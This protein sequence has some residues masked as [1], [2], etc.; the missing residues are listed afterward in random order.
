MQELPLVV[1]ALHER[2]H[3]RY[4]GPQ[5][6]GRFDVFLIDLA[7]WKLSLT[8]QTP[9]IWIHKPEHQSL[10]AFDLAEEI[11]DAVR[12][13]RLAHRSGAG[14]GGLADAGTARRAQ[15]GVHA[16]RAFYPVRRHRFGAAARHSRRRFAHARDARFTAR[17]NSAGAVVAV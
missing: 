13:G 3:F 15:G 12:A 2:L 9:G 10:P 16:C 7:D 17:S 6:L 1:R 4:R 14:L 11:R 8:D 5:H